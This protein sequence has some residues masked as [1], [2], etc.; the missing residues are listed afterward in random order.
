MKSKPKKAKTKKIKI[1]TEIYEKI[2]KQ[3]D[4]TNQSIDEYAEKL[5]SNHKEK[6]EKEGNGADCG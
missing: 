4:Q 2:K 1:N 6:G 3:A 5:L